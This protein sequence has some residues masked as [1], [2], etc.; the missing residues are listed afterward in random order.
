[1]F[2]LRELTDSLFISLVERDDQLLTKVKPEAETTALAN[3]R[4]A[5]AGN[6]RLKASLSAQNKIFLKQKTLKVSE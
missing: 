1:L 5:T 2:A 4:L 6:M 3:L